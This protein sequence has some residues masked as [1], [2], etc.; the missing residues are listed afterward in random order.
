M[1]NYDFDGPNGPTAKS[2]YDFD[3]MTDADFTAMLD[4]IPNSAELKTLVE[5][6]KV[7]AGNE[8][9]VRKAVV[10]AIDLGFK[11]AKGGIDLA[12]LGILI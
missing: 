4:K 10:K 3:K 12:S 9:M 11:A 2:K 8:A 6:M 5:G 7:V 1:P